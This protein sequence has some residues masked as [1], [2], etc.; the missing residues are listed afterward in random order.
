MAL[1]AAGCVGGLSIGTSAL[2]TVSDDTLTNA[3]LGLWWGVLL[4]Y[5][6]L[7]PFLHP[8]KTLILSFLQKPR[9]FDLGRRRLAD[10]DARH[11]ARSVGLAVAVRFVGIG[12]R[13]A[14]D[15]DVGKRKDA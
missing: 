11:F 9:V 1:G 3:W 4:F 12:G 6:F 14:G 2:V 5:F 15:D 10:E 13:V 7:S 8:S